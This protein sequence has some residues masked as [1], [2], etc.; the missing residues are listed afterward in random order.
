MKK[1]DRADR[2]G[3][4]GLCLKKAGCIALFVLCA[5]AALKILFAG[6][7]IDEQYAVSMAY[8]MVKGDCMVSVMWEPHQTSG[9]LCALLMIP[10][11]AL[12]HTTTGIILYLRICGLLIHGA[13]GYCLYRT[14]Q[15]YLEREYV[16]LVCCVYF[17]ALPKIMFLP[18]FSNIQ[19]WCLVMS[20]LSL[21]RYY[22]PMDTKQE[23]G[24]LRELVSAGCF[25]TLEVFSYP[26][27]LFAFV[28]CVCGVVWCGRRL[29]HSLAKEL[30]CLI[31][32]CLI[33]FTAFIIYL[34]SYIPPQDLPDL[35]STIV[36]DGSHS[37]PW[38]E[39]LYG[40]LQSV[41]Q[42]ALF[43]LLYAM[44][45]LALGLLWQKKTKRGFSMR[46][47]CELLIGCTLVG[48]VLIWLFA[49]KYP[50]YP[51]AEY[52]FLPLMIICAAVRHKIKPGPI[53]IFFVWVPLAAFAGVLVFSNH[54]LM[55]SSPFLAPCAVGIFALP[56][57]GKSAEKKC[58]KECL[59]MYQGVLILWVCVLLF[60]RCYLQRTTGGRHETVFNNMSLMR[61]GPAAWLVAD[62]P[63]VVRYRDN[64]DLVTD[65]LPA[66]AKVFYIG[67]R[68]DIYLMKELEYCT[69]STISSPT[70]DDRIFYY[71]ERRPDKRPEYVVCDKELLEENRWVID[72]VGRECLGSPVGENDFLAIYKIAA[73]R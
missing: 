43:F 2:D 53:L 16:F 47:W 27:T 39:R 64:L 69:P 40:H 70:F 41:G 68:T 36:N 46:L 33:G 19:V 18:E 26:S 73:T 13:V 48:Q 37:A 57:I 32:P 56:E 49:D 22:G 10:Y 1:L 38:G 59:G 63:A 50:N 24:A 25:M 23:G 3:F 21:I 7:D 29:P 45:A 12:F 20:I 35:I 58:V 5:A 30:L 28:A 11:M 52:I 31:L 67:T 8:R 15:T 17:F 6:Y 62:T 61:G 51:M 9:W 4:G 65:V 55:V 42:I 72:Y 60:G 66:G 54:P 34:F 14:L 71:F 44:A